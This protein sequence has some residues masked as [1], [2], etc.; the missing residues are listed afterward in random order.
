MAS[1][2]GP[3]HVSAVT[4]LVGID[5]EVNTND[6]SGS[7]GV[8]LKAVCSGAIVAATLYATEDG[9]GAVQD[10]AGSLMV[11]DADP[12][13]DSGATAISAANWLKCIG[14]FGITAGLWVTDANGGMVSRGS[15][16]AY[17]PF[18]S[19]ETLYFVWFHTD[20]QDLNDAGGDNEQL[21]FRFWYEVYS[22]T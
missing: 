18:Q 17:V 9:T 15:G 5:E 22:E 3:I 13:I 12:D 7:V 21:E 19:L 8:D 11:F 20:A 16:S 2:K 4:E 6:Y 14:S 10:S 1:K